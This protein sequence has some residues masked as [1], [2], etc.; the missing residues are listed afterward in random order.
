[1][2][3]NSNQFTITGY[4]YDTVRSTVSTYAYEHVYACRSIN[5]AHS[6]KSCGSRVPDGG[7]HPIQFE[8]E[9]DIGRDFWRMRCVE[10]WEG[11]VEARGTRLLIITRLQTFASSIAHRHALQ[12]HLH[13]TFTCDQSS[14]AEKQWT[15]DSFESLT[16][17]IIDCAWH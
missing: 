9:E 12:N 13:S 5:I 11:R 3:K 10:S 1:M 16:C 15:C 6:R 2:N 7:F 4:A 14:I 17:L 8:L